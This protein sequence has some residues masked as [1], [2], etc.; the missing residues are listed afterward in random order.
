[1]RQTG[2]LMTVSQAW[3]EVQAAAG[4]QPVSAILRWKR[5]AIIAARA[6]DCSR[7]REGRRTAR[8]AQGRGQPRHPSLRSFLLFAASDSGRLASGYR[9]AAG[10]TWAARGL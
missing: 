4:A 9:I 3:A 10:P 1:M 8:H 6:R 2:F 7:L 5:R